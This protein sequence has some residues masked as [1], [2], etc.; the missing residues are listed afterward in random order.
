MQTTIGWKHELGDYL[1]YHTCNYSRLHTNVK[2]KTIFKINII[3]FLIIHVV[4]DFNGNHHKKIG[5]ILKR[6][7]TCNGFLKWCRNPSF[8]LA[9]KAMGLQGCE[10]RGSSGVKARRS[11]RVKARGSPGIKAKRSPGV[12]SHTPRSVRKCEGVWGSE[13]SHSQDNSHFGRWNPDGLLKLQ[14]TIAGVKTQW[15]V[16]FFIS[17]ENSWNLDV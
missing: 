4:I 8:G 16:A 10:P 11:L 15:L 1:D 2:F 9:T 17:L 12:T 6:L 14:R 5:W 13:P 7:W 3:K